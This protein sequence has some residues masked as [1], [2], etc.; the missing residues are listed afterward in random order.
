MGKAVTRFGRADEW[1]TTQGGFSRAGRAM[2]WS[3][4]GGKS[5][6]SRSLNLLSSGLYMGR[7]RKSLAEWHM[8]RGDQSFLKE[9]I[10]AGRP[11]KV[12]EK[13]LFH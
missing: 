12:I 2:T 4:N 13:T 9:L 8:I 10:E 3:S 1:S 5:G 6:F 7:P 11:K